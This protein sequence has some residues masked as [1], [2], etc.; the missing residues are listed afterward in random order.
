MVELVDTLGSGSSP[1]N[2]VGVRVPLR[3]HKIQ[4]PPNESLWESPVPG[5]KSN[6]LP[7]I[8]YII[9]IITFCVKFARK[10]QFLSSA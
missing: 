4:V 5:T 3:A 7:F 1:S 2:W 6:S 9:L 8:F 10:V